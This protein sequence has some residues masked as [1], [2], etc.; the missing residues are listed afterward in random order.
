MLVVSSGGL[1]SFRSLLLGSVSH[2]CAQHA[3]CPVV[4]IRAE[5]HVPP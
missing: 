1:G 5:P 3:E 4:I 2:Q